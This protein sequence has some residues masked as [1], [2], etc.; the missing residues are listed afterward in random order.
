MLWSRNVSVEFKI[1]ELVKV[2]K[3]NKKK[4]NPKHDRSVVADNLCWIYFGHLFQSCSNYS[5]YW[6]PQDPFAW[7]TKEQFATADHH[8]VYWYWEGGINCGSR[9][10]QT[11]FAN[12]SMY[13]SR[14]DL[15]I[16]IFLIPSKL[17][18]CKWSIIICNWIF[19][20]NNQINFLRSVQRTHCGQLCLDRKKFLIILW[21]NFTRPEEDSRMWKLTWTNSCGTWY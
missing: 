1:V 18:F 20:I 21:K 2:I 4:K 8:I 9:D 6:K 13:R 7:P 11:H 3:T 10:L 19:G 5:V 17:I 16:Q 14:F 15:A 12:N